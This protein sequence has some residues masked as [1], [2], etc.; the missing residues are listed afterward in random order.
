MISLLEAEVLVG[1]LAMVVMAGS[2]A[3]QVLL[4]L[5]VVAEEVP[6]RALLL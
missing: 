1:I 5:G 3:Q 4:A 2:L 6:G